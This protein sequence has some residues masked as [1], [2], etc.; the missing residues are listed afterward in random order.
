M[1]QSVNQHLVFWPHAPLRDER[2]GR[3]PS[4]GV[5]GWAIVTVKFLFSASV[6]VLYL[7]A[8]LEVA[9][10]SLEASTLLTSSITVVRSA[11]RTNERNGGVDLRVT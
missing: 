7:E 9:E 11:A 8:S 10:A 5:A 4:A 6:N 2:D 1:Y 3:R